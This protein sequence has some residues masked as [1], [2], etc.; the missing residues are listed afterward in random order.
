MAAVIVAALRSKQKRQADNTDVADNTDE[1][2]DGNISAKEL[3]AHLQDILVRADLLKERLVFE[4]DMCQMLIKLPLFILSLSLFLSAL[5]E[6]APSGVVHNVHRHLRDH[7]VLGDLS[8][9][10]TTEAI[11]TYIEKFE[12]ANEE[13]QPTS[14][15]YWCESRYIDQHWDEVLHVPVRKC[16]SARQYSLGLIKDASARW[17]P[18]TSSTSGTAAQTGCTDKDAE[19][20]AETVDAHTTCSLASVDSHHKVCEEDLGILLCPKTCGFCSPFEYEHFRDFTKPQVTMLPV[21]VFQS[22]FA[23][24]P[25]H[26]FAEIYEAQPHNPLLT[27]MPALDGRRK[28][29]VLTCIDRARHAET[30]YAHE[31]ECPPGAPA[32]YCKDGKMLLTHKHKYHGDTIYPKMLIEPS[33]D[34]QAMKAV[35]WID[36]QS[37]VVAVNTVIYT[38]GV[39]IFTLLEVDFSMDEA[40]NID[41]SYTMISYRDMINGAKTKFVVCLIL[42][43]LGALLTTI[44][45]LR[46]IILNP[47]DCNWGYVAYELFSRGVLCVYPLILLISWTQQVPMSKEYDLLLHSFLDIQGISEQD[48]DGAMDHYFEVLTHIYGETS[49]LKRHRVIGYLVIYSQFLQFIFYMNAHPKMAVLTATVAGA[50]N[51]LMHFMFLF[52]ILFFML[53]FMAHWMLGEYIKEFGT[54][55]NALLSQMQMFFGEF[56]KA[57]HTDELHGVMLL[58]YWIYAWTFIVVVVL[59]L[60]NFLLAIVVDAFVEVKDHFKDKLFMSDFATD[61]VKVSWT[62]LVSMK[63]RWPSH[64]RLIEYLEAVIADA[65]AD[66]QPAWIKSLGSQGDDEETHD[67]ATCYPE[68]LSGNFQELKSLDQVTHFLLH[69]Y[70]RC[71]KILVYTGRAKRGDEV[72]QRR[73]TESSRFKDSLRPGAA[74]IL[75]EASSPGKYERSEPVVVTCPPGSPEHFWAGQLQ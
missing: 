70:H 25:C 68:E 8:S 41:G 60:L 33:R 4:R 59:L 63:G 37:E 35:D 6:L 32:K 2:G 67:F 53:A 15:K 44:L 75:R 19:L 56:I 1:D 28:G 52:I 57:E 72:V 73:S 5:M 58:M 29:R 74:N 66:D 10:K 24:A 21:V 48:V 49:W 69:Y 23:A 38:E 45:S 36:L 39:E 31:K 20:K 9:V 34:I 13:L 43:V 3:Q 27:L 17:S 71:P 30:E 51:N 40:G 64:K 50:L 16:P 14:A 61:V 26:G 65:D 62:H 18:S 46:H 12:H 42:V 22:R 11:Y 55:G 47:G 7:F 54:Y